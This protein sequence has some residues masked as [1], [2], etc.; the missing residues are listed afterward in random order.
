ME[1]GTV[2]D[3]KGRRAHVLLLVVKNRQIT[4]K[5]WQQRAFEVSDKGREGTGDTKGA[6]AG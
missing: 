4:E 5:C 1:M 6:K 3:G 2:L